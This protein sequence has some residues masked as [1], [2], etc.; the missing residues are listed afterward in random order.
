ME[1]SIKDAV[2]T[3]DKEVFDSFKRRDKKWTKQLN[4][5]EAAISPPT[6]TTSSV[7]PTSAPGFPSANHPRTSTTSRI[8]NRATDGEFCATT[9]NGPD[10]DT[11][12]FILPFSREQ[13]GSTQGLSISPSTPPTNRIEVRE[14]HGLLYQQIQKGDDTY[15]IQLVVPKTLIQQTVTVVGVIGGS[16]ILPCSSKEPQP[17][18]EDITVNWKHLDSLSVYDIIKGKGSVEEQHPKYKNRAESVAKQYQK[19]DFSLKLKNLQYNDTGNYQC[20]IT[21]ESEV[22]TVELLIEGLYYCVTTDSPPKYSDGTRLHITD[23]TLNLDSKNYTVGNHTVVKCIEKDQSH[24]LIILISAVFNGV[25]IIVII[26]LVKVFVL[27]SKR[28]RDDLKRSQDPH[29][30]QP[31]VLDL[32]QPQILSQVQQQ[33]TNTV[34]EPLDLIPLS[35]DERIYVK[36]RNDRE[37]SRLYYCVTTDAPPKYSNGTD[38]T[39]LNLKPHMFINNVTIDDSGPYYCVTTDLPTQNTVMAPDYTTLQQTT[40]TVEEPL[41]L[42]RLSLDERIY[43]KMRNDRELRG[44]L[45]AYDQHLNMILGDVE[46]TV[47]TVEIDEETYEE[48]YK[49]TKRN[50]PMLFVRG[51]GVV[52]VAPPLRVG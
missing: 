13:L 48:I 9:P 39:S 12:F 41:D 23:P 50:I 31:Q 19:G 8:I 24:L 11:I 33:T 22:E 42:I 6:A 47:T 40:N 15:K 5:P 3:L 37:T 26:G 21:A 49:S 45:H 44:R 51:D 38:Y 17:R 2:S 27:G 28:T 30:Q 46:E 4:D 25:L 1:E 14:H 7:P 16:V 43:V 29:L 52:L 34:E 10:F 35:L 36:M 32:E 20:Y 18:V